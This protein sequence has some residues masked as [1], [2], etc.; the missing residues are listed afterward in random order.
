MT[1][2]KRSH[3]EHHYPSI[4]LMQYSPA[5]LSSTINHLQK[6]FEVTSLPSSNLQDL[7]QKLTSI[8]KHLLH[9]DLNRLLHILYRIDVEEQKVKEAMLADNEGAI[10][11]NIAQLIINR[12]IQKA[13]IRFTYS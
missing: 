3:L 11:E 10:A 6:V 9:A 2:L 1:W 4:Y 13:Y 12:E 5:I 8:I 7:Q